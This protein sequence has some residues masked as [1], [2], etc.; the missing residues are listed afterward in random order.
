MRIVIATRLITD[1][2]CSH[3]DLSSDFE[4]HLRCLNQTHCRRY[5]VVECMYQVSGH[6][7][8]I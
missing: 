1:L 7:P 2:P 4:H 3:A 6:A 5:L 8:S